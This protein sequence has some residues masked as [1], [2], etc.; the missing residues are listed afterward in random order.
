VAVWREDDVTEEQFWFVIG[1]LCQ[2]HGVEELIANYGTAGAE[3][4]ACRMTAVG[5]GVVCLM[6]YADDAPHYVPI[7]AI[8]SIQFHCSGEEGD[9]G[10][11]LVAPAANDS[12]NVVRLVS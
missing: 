12:G 2:E 4:F 10:S 11:Q 7:S 6:D 8:E 3:Y 1:S 9:G 5:K